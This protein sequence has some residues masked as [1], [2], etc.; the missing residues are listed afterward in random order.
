MKK[1]EINIIFVITSIVLLIMISKYLQGDRY[2][3][4]VNC[5]VMQINKKH[6]DEYDY[7]YKDIDEDEDI[8]KDEDIDNKTNNDSQTT[9]IPRAT[10]I[11]QPYPTGLPALPIHISANRSTFFKRQLPFDSDFPKGPMGPPG[12]PGYGPPEG[13]AGGYRA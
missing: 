5:D 11:R 3:K 9:T 6:F 1:S 2:K 10:I 8:D 4:T 12:A 7:Q 13:P